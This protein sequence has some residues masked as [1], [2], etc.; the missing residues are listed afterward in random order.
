MPAEARI[1]RFQPDVTAAIER[2]PSRLVLAP[3]DARG[4]IR[5]YN[6][7]EYLF[8]TNP[9]ERPF[10]G[11]NLTVGEILRRDDFAEDVA[12]RKVM[13]FDRT[14]MSL[15]TLS[16]IL[17]DDQDVAYETITG[18]QRGP[19]KLTRATYD[20][21][22]G[23]IRTM[24]SSTDGTGNFDEKKVE[25]L[26]TGVVIGDLG[27][28]GD[29][30][31]RVEELTGQD[32][33]DHDRTL[34]DALVDERVAPHLAR[35]LPS[36][37]KLDD[38]QRQFLTRVIASGFHEPQLQQAEIRPRQTE[39]LQN[40]SR[41]EVD[42]N[43][44]LGV[45]DIA[46]AQGNQT[47]KGS[48]TLTESTVQTALDVRD[49][50]HFIREEEPRAGTYS[51]YEKQ[52]TKFGWSLLTA[53]DLTLTELACMYRYSNSEDA[54]QLKTVFESNLIHQ[55][56]RDIWDDELNRTGYEP[57]GATMVYYL[58]TI[59]TR[60]TEILIQRGL[61][62]AHAMAAALT[63]GAQLLTVARTAERTSDG[64]FVLMANDIVGT[65][66]GL[67]QGDPRELFD[68]KIG[69]YS[70]NENNEAWAYIANDTV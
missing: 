9:L 6:E 29:F 3:D 13:E 11:A 21:F 68:Y 22:A 35:I 70:T 18:K 1:P 61:D 67:I 36:V 38:E 33:I 39:G 5:D 10:V 51:Y 56:V 25:L 40:L 48:L 23:K 28:S 44:A 52:A 53:R 42:F 43:W 34:L 16:L 55:D 15:W 24:V 26:N 41:E 2:L 45:L 47:Q 54:N 4:W 60:G 17:H 14:V 37:A 8:R 59:L 50:M 19:N 58:P 69:V 32:Y 57:D 62:K 31:R 64:V 30:S 27:K 12:S 65:I 7:L 63:I 49:A 66:E 46:G 20:K